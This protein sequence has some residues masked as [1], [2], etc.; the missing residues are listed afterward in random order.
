MDRNAFLAFALSFLVLS[1]W[2]TWEAQNRP[3]P[4]PGSAPQAAAPVIAGS[5]PPGGVPPAPGAAPQPV[6][7]PTPAPAIAAPEEV[8]TIEN[9]VFRVALTSW[10]AAVRRVEL[11]DY[12]TARSEGG[13]PVVLVD[14]ASGE[15][16]AFATPLPELGLG[17]LSRAP[18]RI[19]E[20]DTRQVAFETTQ[21]G[22]RVRKT[23]SFEDESYRLRLR[24]E[25]ANDGKAPVS[26]AFGVVLPQKQQAT[27]DFQDLSVAV[28]AAGSVE[29][30]FVASYGQPG[31]FGGAPTLE[32]EFV[33]DVLWVGGYSHYFVSALLPEVT[34]EARARW[35]ALEPGRE[36]LV[37]VEHPPAAI[38]PGTAL[39]R[40]YT[41]FIGPK[42][43]EL[44]AEVGGQLE[45]SIDL[46][47]SWIA[48]FTRAFIWLLKACYQLIPNYGVAIILLTALVRLVTAPLAAKQ[49][50]S[51]KR[52]GELQ[53]QL[54][55]IQEKYADD[56]QAQSQEMMKLY[57]EAG[58][59]PLGGCLPLLL[60]FP[61]LIGLYYALQ[62]SIDLRQ[63]PFFL[64]I[65]DLSRPETLFTI[66]GVEWPVRVLPILMTL[67]MV[68]Q[69]RMTPMTTM[70]PTQAR[71]MMIVMPVMFFFMFYG[72]PSGLVL[73]WFVS[74]LL[75]IAQQLY[76]NRQMSPKPA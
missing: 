54:K 20:R 73:Y 67:S 42:E 1:L 44:L 13:A 72:F 46:G 41:A 74:N 76:L 62:S 39:E 24:V 71:M 49:M 16:G 4:A 23:F 48:P 7:E 30:E 50:K 31:F 59:N 34:R 8:V 63:A 53:P 47:W 60:Q 55:A 52:M 56:R 9:G 29:R 5:E 6:P 17:D 15:I 66:P 11:L 28:L 65:D 12:T 70:D 10:G 68:V 27:S 18:F 14:R 26:P 38:L 22:V 36:V 51:M 19:V 35:Q 33:G 45:R 57:R 43:P 40:H 58:V 37:S 69:Q 32:Q 25:V 21:N 75:A 64:W 2:M 3:Q 61:V